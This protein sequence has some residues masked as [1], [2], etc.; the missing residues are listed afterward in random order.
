MYPLSSCG[1]RPTN[2]VLRHCS[3]D[4]RGLGR[5]PSLPPAGLSIASVVSLMWCPRAAT[6]CSPRTLHCV[7]GRMRPLATGSPRVVSG[8][9][10][11]GPSSGFA[12]K[13]QSGVHTL[14]A[15]LRREAGGADMGPSPKVFIPSL[16]YR[17][18]AG[19]SR[20]FGGHSYGCGVTGVRLGTDLC[21]GRPPSLRHAPPPP[22]A[23][24]CWRGQYWEA[25]LTGSVGVR[26]LT[27]MGQETFD[28]RRRR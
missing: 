28:S 3:L 11:R 1:T 13:V 20:V 8:A 15:D 25:R 10:I 7:A 24:C 4:G 9:E 22:Q 5:G 14:H 18:R 16:S 26:V 23:V 2:G 6:R 19:G 12:V 27:Q 21:M 17:G